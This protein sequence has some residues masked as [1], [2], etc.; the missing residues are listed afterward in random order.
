MSVAGYS[1][2]GSPGTKVPA[3]RISPPM[4]A[5]PARACRI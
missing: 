1:I 2:C 4:I 3:M 5:A